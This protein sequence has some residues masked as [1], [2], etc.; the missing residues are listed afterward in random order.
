[1]Q[2][3]PGTSSERPEQGLEV[4]LEECVTDEE[5]DYFSESDDIDSESDDELLV[6]P[7]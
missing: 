5:F 2:D 6:L 7:D 1:M 3:E 4:V